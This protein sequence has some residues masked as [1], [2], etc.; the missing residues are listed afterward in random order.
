VRAAGMCVLRPDGR[1][2]P[3][4]RLL[5]QDRAARLPHRGA[6]PEPRRA[7]D[8]LPLLLYQLLQLVGLTRYNI[9]VHYSH[10]LL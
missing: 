6:Q 4:G 2:D 3:G 9:L 10:S 1:G 5:G 7:A 8:H